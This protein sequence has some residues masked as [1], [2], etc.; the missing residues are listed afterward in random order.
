MKKIKLLGM[1][2]AMVLTLS[3]CGSTS[4]NVDTTKQENEQTIVSPEASESTNSTEVVDNETSATED[5]TFGSNVLV[6]V[7]SRTGENYQVG[8]IEKGNTMIVAEMVQEGTGADLFEIKPKTPYP[9][10]YDEMLDVA[11]AEQ[12]SDARPA[13]LE[14]IDSI[15]Q[16]DTIFV[17]YPI[18]WGNMP[19]IVKTFLESYDF[20]GKTVIPFST[21]AGSGL[22]GTGSTIEDMLPD[23]TLM[24]GFAISGQTAQENPDSAREMVDEWLEDNGF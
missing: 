1:V 4:Q 21:H 22:A 3:A 14:P 2:L 10:A 6:A 20:T 13:M 5:N 24:D 12:S 17:G 15:E 23:A 16:Y 18:W 19:N 7:F 8:V 9:D 11:T